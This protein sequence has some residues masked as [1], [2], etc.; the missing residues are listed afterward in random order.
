MTVRII[1]KCFK[2][3]TAVSFLMKVKNVRNSSTLGM[4]NSYQYFRNC[5]RQGRT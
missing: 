5:P 2:A 4:K 3:R 1:T